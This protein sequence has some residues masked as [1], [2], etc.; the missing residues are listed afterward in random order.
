MKR[1]NKWFPVYGTCM[2]FALAGDMKIYTVCSGFVL[3]QKISEITWFVGETIFKSRD[4]RIFWS[5]TKL[6]HTVTQAQLGTIIFDI[7]GGRILTDSSITI[8]SYWTSVKNSSW[9]HLVPWQRAS[10]KIFDFTGAHIKTE[11]I[12][13]HKWTG[14]KILDEPDKNKT[15]KTKVDE[16][17]IFLARPYMRRP[18]Y[19]RILER[20]FVNRHDFVTACAVFFDKKN[21]PV[22]WPTGRFAAEKFSY[23]LV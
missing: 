11:N 12:F 5:K 17:L 7:P 9:Q 14:L 15:K 22:G 4:R 23:F 10:C 13:L 3:L 21:P 1:E 19:S 8:C 20:I 18:L 2:A 6:E 16:P